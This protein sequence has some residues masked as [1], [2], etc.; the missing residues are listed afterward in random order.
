MESPDQAKA[1]TALAVSALDPC[2]A[3]DVSVA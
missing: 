3:F 1:A 2:V